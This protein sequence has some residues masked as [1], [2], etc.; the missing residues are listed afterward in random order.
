MESAGSFSNV[1]K[2]QPPHYA[3][4]W[5]YDFSQLD[6]GT[7]DGQPPLDHPPLV[8]PPPSVNPTLMRN[9]ALAAL[10]TIVLL[11][12]VAAVFVR[13]SLRRALQRA[14]LERLKWRVQDFE[15]SELHSDAPSTTSRLSMTSFAA[16]LAEVDDD[17]GDGGA[18]ELRLR[19]MAV[20]G[21]EQ[22]RRVVV[23]VELALTQAQRQTLR[24]SVCVF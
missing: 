24:V 1:A 16:S 6:F 19:S 7:P 20:D 2:A 14:E 4:K 9:I 5:Q 21:D 15:L 23:L 11:G 18:D 12:G 10:A 13:I 17:D 8:H 3:L 22:Q